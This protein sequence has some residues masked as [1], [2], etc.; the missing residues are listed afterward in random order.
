MFVLQADSGVGDGHGY[1]C[2]MN[3]RSIRVVGVIAL[4]VVAAGCRD[5]APLHG[6]VVDPPSEAPVVQVAGEGAYNLDSERGRRAVVLYFG[7]THCP[8]VCPATLADWAV[9]IGASERTVARLFRTGLGTSFQQWRQQA[10]LAHALPLLARGTP[11]SHVAALS[12]Y[13]SDSAFSAMFK[14]AMG[15]PPSQ[16]MDKNGP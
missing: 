10:V 2:T 8:D 4:V 3:R 16:F 6:M 15:Q 14:A 5:T 7:Y 11:V 9:G 13:A 12:G 1:I